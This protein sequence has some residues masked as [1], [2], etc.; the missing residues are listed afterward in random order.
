MVGHAR[1][2]SSRDA[3]F[4]PTPW[5]GFA[6]RKREREERKE[7]ARAEA[8]ANAAND[9][10]GKNAKAAAAAAA[11]KGQEEQEEENEEEIGPSPSSSAQVL[12]VGAQKSRTAKPGR[13][14]FNDVA[15]VP[16]RDCVPRVPFRAC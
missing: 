16:P 3:F 5:S 1:S 6:R 13:L 7:A 12:L 11:A 4:L 9:P 14:L 15:T 8:E 10:K 2:S